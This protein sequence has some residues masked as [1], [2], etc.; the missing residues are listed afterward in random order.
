MLGFKVAFIL[1]LSTSCLFSQVDSTSLSKDTTHSVK[2]AMI[3][4]AI[5]PGAGQVYNHIAMP[6]GKKKAFWKV[7][8]IYAGLG[9]ST[10]F[11]IKNQMLQ[12]SLKTEYNN[13]QN[14]N[15]LNPDWEQYDDYGVLVLY[16]QHLD[17]RDLSI[18]AVGAIYLLQ[19]ADAGV[20][21][22]FVRFDI[23]RDL[24]LNVR[25]TVL[26]NR[27]PGLQLSLNFR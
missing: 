13:R 24:S 10:Y 5:L 25:P 21:A 3:F 7:P 19:V 2:K 22:H 6:N 20:E 17:R 27:N 14:G 26:Y 16:N 11:L 15:T 9:S 18:L 23:S 4:S 1:I 8:L 12:K